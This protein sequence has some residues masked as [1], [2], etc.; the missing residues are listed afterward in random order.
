MALVTAK[1]AHIAVSPPYQATRE[2]R[3]ALDARLLWLVSP[4]RP[5]AAHSAQRLPR[6]VC[7]D[8]MAAPPGAED[9]INL[10]ALSFDQLNQLKQSIEEVTRPASA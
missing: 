5:T 9:G 2:S 10:H 4:P 6:F 8:D 7:R 1:Q 3:N